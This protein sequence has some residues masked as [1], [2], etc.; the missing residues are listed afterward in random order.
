MTTIITRLYASEQAAKKMAD[1][2]Y[3]NGFPKLALVI[4]SGTDKDAVQKRMAAAQVH[5][6]A[7][8]AYAASVAGG[9]T[10]LLIIRAT[11]KPLDAARIARE[12]TAASETVDIGVVM[13]E[14]YA[15]DLPDHAPSILKTHPKLLSLP[16]EPAELRRGPISNEMGVRLLSA[17]KARTSA[18]SGGRYMSKAF[19]PMK[20]VSTGRN[21]SSAMSGGPMM[22]RRFWPMPLLSDAPRRNAVIRGGGTVF[23]RMFGWPTI[24][25]ST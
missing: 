20:L 13:D 7:A 3:W 15:P 5:E 8:P 18:M 17:P 24:I 19:W 25:R 11:Y 12:M 23:S 9:E 21:A 16:D 10:A 6:D 1:K 4:V 22:A 2:L 14:Y